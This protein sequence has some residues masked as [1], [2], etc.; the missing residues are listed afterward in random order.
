MTTYELYPAAEEDLEGIWQYS[1]DRWGIQQALSYLDDL[2]HAFLL[3]A[4]LHCLPGNVL[5]LIL[6]F[7]F[8]LMPAT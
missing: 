3:L 5:N 4:D 1:V 7:I 6:L 2:H 8:T